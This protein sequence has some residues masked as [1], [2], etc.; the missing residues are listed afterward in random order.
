ME[1]YAH[2]LLRLP[3]A[4]TL[5][6][7]GLGKFADMTAAA[8]MFSLPV[9]LFTVVAIAEVLAAIGII[10]GGIPM[11]PLKDIATRLAGLSALPVLVGAIFM[12][13]FPRFS[14]TPTN[15]FPMGGSEFQLLLLGVAIYFILSGHPEQD[16]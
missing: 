7:H 2:W 9:P 15:E 6:F 8:E 5:A 4:A 11:F 13:H 14:F 10:V 12:V 16:D 3:F 1:T